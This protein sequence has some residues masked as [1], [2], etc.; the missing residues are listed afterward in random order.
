[1][2]FKQINKSTNPKQLNDLDLLN[3]TRQQPIAIVVALGAKGHAAGAGLTPRAPIQ[4]VEGAQVGGKDVEDHG[5]HIG[6]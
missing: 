6:D 3:Q 4:A 1:M 5:R 2:E